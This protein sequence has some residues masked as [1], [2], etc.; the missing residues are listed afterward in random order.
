MIAL[1]FPVFLVAGWSLEGWV[2]AAVLWFASEL[3][4][5]LL[6][7]FRLGAGNLATSGVVG[8]G[9][10]FRALAIGIV[11]IAAAASDTQLGVSAALLYALA[12]TLEL[13]LAPL[14]LH[15]RGPRVIALL[16][17]LVLAVAETGTTED[18]FDP[19]HEFELPAWIPIHIGP[20][21]MSINKA[22]AYL[23][24][25]SIVTMALGIFTMR[26]RVGVAPTRARRSASRSTKSRS[27][28]SPSRGCRRRR[29]AAGSRTWRRSS[30]SSGP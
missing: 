16:N 18:E 23:I 13:G 30:S 24:L 5:A 4:A 7:R 26:F 10:S 28:R 27:P 20:I 11:L 3:L 12:Y 15:A 25:A 14:L 8:I 6:A 29:S 1:A 2:L 22:V 21:D 9:M 19:S 17:T